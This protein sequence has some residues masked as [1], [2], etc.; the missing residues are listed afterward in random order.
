M[1]NAQSDIKLT[2]RPESI[3]GIYLRVAVLFYR[4]RLVLDAGAKT[5][6]FR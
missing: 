5:W 3:E 4:E 1:Q 6:S 2:P